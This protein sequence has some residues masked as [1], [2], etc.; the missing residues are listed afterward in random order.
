MWKCR[1]SMD[2]IPCLRKLFFSK[3]PLFSPE[4][5]K[6]LFTDA[7][8][9]QILHRDQINFCFTFP[10]ST[11]TKQGTILYITAFLNWY[12]KMLALYD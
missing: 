12:F 2:R 4:K 9:A 7:N 8:I 10:C 6:V 11:G 1:S 3:T 5:Q